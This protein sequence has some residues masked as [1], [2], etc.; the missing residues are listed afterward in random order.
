M[1]RPGGF[2]SMP[3]VNHSC[4]LVRFRLALSLSAILAGCEQPSIAWRDPVTIA[5]P[6]GPARLSV[7]ATGD[8]QWIRDSL[9]TP[10]VSNACPG[11]VREARDGNAVYATWWEPHADSTARLYAAVSAD[12]GTTWK[13]SVAVDT[14]DTG[15]QGCNRPA[16]SVA[17]SGADV[18]IAYSMRSAEGTGVFLVHSMERGAMFHTPIPVSYG[19]RIVDVAVAAEG[20]TVVV[21]YEEPSGAPG[22][23]SLAVSRTQGHAIE[24]HTQSSR[25]VDRAR[26]PTVAMA[27]HTIAV[28]WRPLE[29]TD[30]HAMTVRVGT[31]EP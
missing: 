29:T 31:I 7:N 21:A 2:T 4:F 23:I 8:T 17:V 16:P 18:H 30:A 1:I 28:A 25:T 5:A 22:R 27:G 19:D 10:P 26:S 11:S 13:A 14:A 3:R 12:A 24:I 20:T 9:V 6:D 15:D